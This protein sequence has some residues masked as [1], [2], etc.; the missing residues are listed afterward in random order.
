M[1]EN[2]EDLKP[3]EGEGTGEAPK[4]EKGKKDKG[5][6]KADKAP[7]AEK[8]AGPPVTL[9]VAVNIPGVRDSQLR[10]VVS[11]LTRSL[12]KEEGVLPGGVAVEGAQGCRVRLEK[13]VSWERADEIAEQCREGLASF[14]FIT[15]ERYVSVKPQA[16]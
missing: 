13:G 12:N 8:V 1:S 15:P 14:G 3:G 5:D 11:L 10:Q 7:K 4:A 6:A 16:G 2:T 9:T